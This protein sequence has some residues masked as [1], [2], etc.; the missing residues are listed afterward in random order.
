MTRKKEIAEVNGEKIYEWQLFD[1][2]A[3]YAREVLKKDL[4][5]LTPTEYNESKEEALDKLIASELLI[6]EALSAGFNIDEEAVEQ[7]INDLKNSFTSDYTLGEYLAERDITIEELK[8]VMRKQLI[9]ENFV[10]QIISRIPIP[11]N[12]DVESYFEKVK[13]KLCYPPKFEFFACYISNPTEE[14]KERFKNAFI[15][16]ANKKMEKSF[17]ESIMK[18]ANDIS[19]KI[20]F[21]YYEKTSDNLPKEFIDLLMK[22]EESTFSPIYEAEDELSIFYLIKKE[23]NKPLPEDS[24]KEEVKKYLSIIRVKKILDAYIDTLK[25]KYTI[26]VFLND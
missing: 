23:L 3:G 20:I 18:S 5:S 15:N 13:D 1:T 4:S 2:M 21:N 9:K 26:K 19:E 25:E 14:E 24:A 11:T 22:I 16:L 10:S 17:A 12:K 7:A 8:N 6:T